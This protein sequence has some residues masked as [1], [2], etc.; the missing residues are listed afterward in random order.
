VTVSHPVHRN[1]RDAILQ[2]RDVYL[3][4]IAIDTKRESI[5]RLEAVEAQEEAALEAKETELQ[6]FRDEFSG[7]LIRDGK[8][9]METRRA[10]EAKSRRR[11]EVLAEIKRVSSEISALRSDIAHHTEMLKECTAYR[12]LLEDLTPPEWR[13]D[14]PP[15]ALYFTDPRQLITILMSLEE[16]NLFLK[17]HCQDAEDALERARAQ[18]NEFMEP[19]DAHIDVSV[20]RRADEQARLQRLQVKTEQYRVDGEFRHGNELGDAELAELQSAI[21]EF[22]GVLGF[23]SASRN[24]TPTMLRRIE[25]MLE[26]MSHRLSQLDAKLMKEKTQERELQRRNQERGEKNVRDKKEQEEKMQ[27]AIQLAMMPIKKRTGRPLVERMVPRKGDSREKREEALRQQ[28]AQEAADADL[29]Y[30]A[31]WD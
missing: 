26:V 10:A 2:K 23:D 3:S 27:K 30:G 31:I 17:Q 16:E 13:R 20:A 25:G 14:H 11:V 22:H 15:P 28:M 21:T 8:Q 4:Q 29:F 7:F 24:D 12:I 9:T 19:R 18:F 6:A 5:Q 1:T